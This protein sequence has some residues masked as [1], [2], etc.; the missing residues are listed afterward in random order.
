VTQRQ[1]AGVLVSLAAAHAG[2]GHLDVALAIASEA[3]RLAQDMNDSHLSE[4]LQRHIERYSA[5]LHGRLRR[6]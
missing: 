4:V 3:K 5:A 6:Q 2:V 1:N